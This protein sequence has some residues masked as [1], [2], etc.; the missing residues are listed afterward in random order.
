MTQF[1]A[2]SIKEI[3]LSS[4]FFELSIRGK[5][6]ET[7]EI[8]IQGLMK[9][10]NH[11][12]DAW[13]NITPILKAY[14]K[15]LSHWLRNES[16]KEYINIQT[17]RVFNSCNLQQL[18]DG[19]KNPF[20]KSQW[21]KKKKYDW[22]KS[23]TPLICTRTGRY[24]SGTWLHK[25][26]FIEFITVL[27]VNLRIELHEVIEEIVK[28]ATIIK[29]ERVGTKTLFHELADTIKDIYI[30]AQTSDNAIKFAYSSLMTLAN[31]K[32]L[33]TTAKKYCLDN[34]IKITKEMISVRDALDKNILAQ[35]KKVEKDINGFIRYGGVT[36]YNEL[37]NKILEKKD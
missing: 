31:M 6:G 34:D 19:T 36:N 23:D 2:K 28:Q 7:I 1:L 35:I 22:L 32:V 5:D 9:A 10:D 27:D 16:V 24:H 29:I 4:K 12:E 37:K 14:N 25:K 17:N 20:P 8:D 30:P 21:Y 18:K 26:L 11:S 13:I 15:K 33:G 3:T